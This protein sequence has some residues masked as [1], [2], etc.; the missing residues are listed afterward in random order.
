MLPKSCASPERRLVWATYRRGMVRSSS[1]SST[2]SDAGWGCTLRS[3]QALLGAA[4]ERAVPPSKD[5][6]SDFVVPL[7]VAARLVDWPSPSPPGTGTF[8]LQSFLAC[9]RG[10]RTS[11]VTEGEWWGPHA[12]SHAARELARSDPTLPFAVVLAPDATVSAAEVEAGGKADAAA[13]TAA[14][15]SAAGPCGAADDWTRPVLLLVPLRL[16]LVRP[17]DPRLLAQLGRAARLPAFAGAVGGTPRHSLLLVG[18]C[19]RDKGEADGAVE[20]AGGGD[21]AS[22]GGR[23][24]SSRQP[25]AFLCLDPHTVQDAPPSPPPAVEGGSVA[26]ADLAGLS[27]FAQSLR[28]PSTHPPHG[29]RRATTTTTTTIEPEAL[30]PTVAVSF[31]F[32]TRGEFVDWRKALEEEVDP[33][34]VR[35]F[36]V[37]DER[38]DYEAAASCSGSSSGSSSSGSG[39][40]SGTGSTT[41]V[42]EEDSGPSSSSA[43]LERSPPPGVEETPADGDGEW[44]VV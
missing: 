12:A 34:G 18:V 44:E 6:E 1:S 26:L 38:Q 20:G 27:V 17:V 14:A 5:E 33:D 36:V 22:D 42:G 32:R 43:S 10:G 4:L 15:A 8:A 19:P 24:S 23:T 41:V 31:F 28:P 39:G 40:S 11:A 13:A 16:G 25:F 35:L 2:F 7:H 30:D 9:K 37:V 21:A 3:M 29:R